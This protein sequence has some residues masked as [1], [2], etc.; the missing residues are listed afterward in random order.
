MNSMRALTYVVSRLSRIDH[1]I[2]LI[3]EKDKRNILWSHLFCRRFL[4]RRSFIICLNIIVTTISIYQQHANLIFLAI[5]GK[6]ENWGLYWRRWTKKEG[7][8]K[9]CLILVYTLTIKCRNKITLLS[10]QWCWTYD[11]PFTNGNSH[12]IFVWRRRLTWC[13]QRIHL[14][15]VRARTPQHLFDGFRKSHVEYPLWYIGHCVGLVRR[16]F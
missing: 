5:Y 1:F 8:H 7:S 3:V 2:D 14:L 16:C 6:L 12:R 10:M 4:H 13:L 9:N 15:S 11:Y